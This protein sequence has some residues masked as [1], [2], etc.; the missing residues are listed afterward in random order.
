MC[1]KKPYTSYKHALYDMKEL[2]NKTDKVYVVYTCRS[3]CDCF[4]VGTLGEDSP[5]RHRSIKYNR[6]EISNETRA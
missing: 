5:L 6:L 1:I 3:G 2:R 4:H